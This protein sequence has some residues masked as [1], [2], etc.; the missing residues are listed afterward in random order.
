MQNIPENLKKH[1]TEQNYEA[2]TEE[3]HKT[4]QYIMKHLKSFLS[5]KA[6]DSYL[7]GLE[8]TGITIDRIPRITDI[9]KKLQVLGWRAVP[10]S[11]FIP[12]IAFMEFQLN[13]ILP[14]ATAIRQAK[15][16]DYTPAPDIVH[17]AAGHTPF[18]IDPVFNS[19]LKKF[20]GVIRKSI[21]NKEEMEQY[22]VIRKLSD[23][24]EDP[25]SSPEEIQQT[26]EHLK[27]I[28]AQMPSP[29]EAALLSRFIWWTSEYG[30]IGDTKN[31]K[32]YGAGL[33][34]S[35]G[36]SKKCFTSE[37]KKIPLDSSCV[38]YSYDITNYQPQLFVTPSFE[39]LHEVLEELAQQA[40][41]YKGGEY[42][43][44]LAHKSGT[45]CTVQLD[46]GLQISGI[47]EQYIMKNNQ[48]AFI[49]LKGACQ[50]SYKDKELSGHSKEV[51]SSGYS[52]PLGPLKDSHKCLN[53]ISVSELKSLFE[54]KKT[55][56]MTLEFA[57]GWTLT[58]QL[59]DHY[60]KDDWLILLRFKN[61]H[62]FKGDETYFQP[63][64]G[65]FDLAVGEKIVSVF[66]GPA[67]RSAFKDF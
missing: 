35:I 27:Q 21:I 1:I 40:A 53:R 41:F 19:F 3:N 33:L 16:I 7:E 34:S 6:H 43:L 28:N 42:G 29:S 10:V 44:K 30:L 11:G 24:K 67:D 56:V 9:D 36:E 47:L 2:Y 49:K 14:I 57:L 51:H 50:L 4:W 15:H 31:Y 61:C 59:T 58:G 26:E 25:A 52:T 48:P 65:V 45:V 63:Q 37:I 46:T 64:W 39:A 62:V 20:A 54:N 12:P 32:I 5:E 23:I 8:K 66:G 17:E 22:Q 55:S 38:N 13:N 18:L 60:I